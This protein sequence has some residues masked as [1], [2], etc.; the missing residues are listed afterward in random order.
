MRH[1]FQH[2]DAPLNPPPGPS[3]N[4]AVPVDSPRVAMRV[5]HGV[6]EW[7]VFPG[8]HEDDWH[9]EEP[10]HR[11]WRHLFPPALIRAAVLEADLLLRRHP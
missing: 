6:R 4:I 11:D 2:P 7:M 3:A 8:A 5:I 9:E 1:Y 10:H